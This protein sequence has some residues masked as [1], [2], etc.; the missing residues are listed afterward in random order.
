M[1]LILCHPGS[2]L[3]PDAPVPDPDAAAILS[4]DERKA[5]MRQVP[6]VPKG[7]H[8]VATRRP[9]V[10]EVKIYQSP[11]DPNAHFGIGRATTNDSIARQN[12]LSTVRYIESDGTDKF[13]TE[14]DIPS[15]TLKLRTLALVLKSWDLTDDNN[16]PLPINEATIGAYLDPAEF[17]FLVTKVFDVNPMWS[18]NGGNETVVKNDSTPS[19]EPSSES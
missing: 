17:E 14:R 16:A 5:L 12:I 11:I 2:I 19:S 15:G 9:F 3:F 4:R 10:G 1:G 8:P 13:V 7:A 6:Q 18:N